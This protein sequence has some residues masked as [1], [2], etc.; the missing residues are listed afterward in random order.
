MI[1]Y[2]KTEIGTLFVISGKK[3]I[4]LVFNEFVNF[5]KFCKNV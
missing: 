1:L 4:D 2:C 3:N 5:P